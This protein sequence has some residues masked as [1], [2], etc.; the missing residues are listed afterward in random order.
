MPLQKIITEIVRNV[1]RL[2]QISSSDDGHDDNDFA[3]I[4][5][6]RTTTIYSIMF[7]LLRD[8]ELP[9]EINSISRI[10]GSTCVIWV[11]LKK[12]MDGDEDDEEM[13]KSPAIPFGPLS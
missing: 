9:K 1:K 10:L 8:E 4:S 11:P 7:P 6:S 5:L 12:M 2:L 13:K 3:E